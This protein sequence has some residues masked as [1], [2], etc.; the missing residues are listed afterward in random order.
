MLKCMSWTIYEHITPSGKRY[1]GI[2]SKEY[3]E[4]RWRNGRGYIKDTPFGKAIE[5]YKWDNIQ[6]NILFDDLT[7]KEA[8]W[9]ENYLI[10]Y[11]WTF[12]GFKDSKGYN[13]TLGGEGKIGYVTSEESRRKN[14]EAHKG[15]HCSEE[16]RRRM[17]ESKK[18][19]TPWKGKHHTEE[20]K[21]KIRESRKGIP[22]DEETKCKISEAHK[23]IP[24]DEETK[25][26][27]G[28]ANKG[29]HRV[30]HEDGTFHMER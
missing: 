3:P 2:T 30:Y 13:C 27:I 28:E 25:R 6:H 9:L 5:K 17:S 16:T 8:K 26:K 15:K 1:I 4:D 14:S 12:V 23:G 20:S 19:K 21:M 24:R 10:C 22:R 7:E 11:Y 18:G 29:T